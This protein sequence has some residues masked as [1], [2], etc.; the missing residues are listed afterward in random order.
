MSHYTG[1]QRKSIAAAL[2]G[3]QRDLAAAV[4]AELAHSG[5]Q[6]LIDPVHDRGEEAIANEL[7]DLEHLLSE[8]HVRELRAVE[9]ARA[10]LEAGTLG[11][12]AECGGD[13]GFARLTANP[14]AV[15]CVACQAAF[16]KKA[17]V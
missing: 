9:A 11:E 10:R 13:I 5:D 12:C 7:S 6:H 14:V 8:Q 15:R 1:S 2:A 4:R 3:R 16:E 17:P